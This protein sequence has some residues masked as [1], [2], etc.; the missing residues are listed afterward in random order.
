M[1]NKCDETKPSKYLTYLDANNLYGWA[2]SQDLP[3][4]GF[5]WMTERELTNWRTFSKV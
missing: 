5:D 4:G 1:G 2:E 3:T